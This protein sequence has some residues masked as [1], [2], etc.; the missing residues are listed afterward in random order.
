MNKNNKDIFELM[1]IKEEQK[2]DFEKRKKLKGYYTYKLIGL[3]LSNNYA[4]KFSYDQ[5]NSIYRYDKRLRKVLYNYIGLIEEYLRALIINK[6]ENEEF[7]SI[8]KDII[9]SNNKQSLWKNESK[10][11]Y[12]EKIKFI[13]NKTRI[14]NDYLE[15]KIYNFLNGL[16]FKELINIIKLHSKLHEINETNIKNWEE[17]N[18]LRNEV[19]HNKFLLLKKIQYKYDKNLNYENKIINFYNLISNNISDDD[20]RKEFIKEFNNQ[21]NKKDNDEEKYNVHIKWDLR[22]EVKIILKE[23]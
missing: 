8:F 14:D 18:K 20:I 12:D 19:S 16:Q 7:F 11:Y 6:I 1:N 9:N 17:V 10:D 22:E 2:N 13:I 5:L 23:K 15:Y 21:I 4:N 3:Y